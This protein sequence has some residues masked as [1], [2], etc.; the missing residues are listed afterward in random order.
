MLVIGTMPSV[1]AACWRRGRSADF[2]SGARIPGGVA[3]GVC[4]PTTLVLIAR[5]IV[6]L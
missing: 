2:L 4:Y 5:L 6:G 3:G 1:P